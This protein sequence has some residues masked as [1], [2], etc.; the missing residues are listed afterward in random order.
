VGG[1]NPHIH[2]AEGGL[3]IGEGLFV[4]LK[5]HVDVDQSLLSHLQMIVPELHYIVSGLAEPL[6]ALLKQQIVLS[7]LLIVFSRGHYFHRLHLVIV[8]DKLQAPDGYDYVFLHFD[9]PSVNIPLWVSALP[10]APGRAGWTRQKR[11]IFLQ[12]R[13]YRSGRVLLPAPDFPDSYPK[14]SASGPAPSHT[15]DSPGSPS[16]PQSPAAE[17]A[18]GDN[19]CSP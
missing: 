3:I 19:G 10:P 13:W 11:R 2:G 8:L 1:R 14:A 5:H 4:L 12:R 18:A 9:C 17:N 7:V 15:P 6:H 16:P